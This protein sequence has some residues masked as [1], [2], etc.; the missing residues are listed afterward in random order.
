MSIPNYS[1]S[2]RKRTASSAGFGVGPHGRPKETAPSGEDVLTITGPGMPG[3]GTT[4]SFGGNPTIMDARVALIFYGSA[5][6]DL[7][8]SP[9]CLDI[10]SAVKTIFGTPYTSQLIDY[11]CN[12]AF[13]NTLWNRIVTNPP[14]NPFDPSDAGSVAND[15]IDNFYSTLP[16]DRPN[17]YAI[18]LPPGVSSQ[19]AG[20]SGAHSNDGS[21]YYSWQLYGSLDAI[22]TT[23]S[24]ELVE[25]MTDPD[26]NGWQ[27]DPRDSGPNSSWHEI[28]DICKGTSKRVNGVLVASYFSTSFN[29]C[30]VPRPDPPPPPPPTLPNGDYQVSCAVFEYHNGTPYIGIIGGV[31][32]GQSWAMLTDHAIQRIQQ[33]ELTFYTQVGEQRA[34]VEI[35]H[36]L[37]HAFLTTVADD[38]VENNLD[39]IAKNSRCQIGGNLV[40]WE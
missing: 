13:M 40:L 20:V 28:A 17:F 33:G 7:T 38:S 10:Q 37:V 8:L 30:V 14:G 2:S 5:W 36:S 39:Y 15:L 3:P 35:G 16:H 1:L 34:N 19:E 31:W 21:T 11:Q 9:N 6:N 29:A 27:V 32:N 25:A 22:T 12:G 23:F 26:G 4:V 18:F 24:H